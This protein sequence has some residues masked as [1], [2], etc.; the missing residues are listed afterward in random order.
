MKKEYQRPSINVISMKVEN[1]LLGVSAGTTDPTEGGD[2]TGTTVGG[3]GTVPGGTEPGN[4]FQNSG[5]GAKAG[6]F[7]VEEE[8]FKMW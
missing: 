5:G 2:P 7:D 8:D 6:Q 3:G 1:Q 4:P